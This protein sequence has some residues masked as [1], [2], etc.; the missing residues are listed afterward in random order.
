MSPLC[1]QAKQEHSI[2][3]VEGMYHHHW[4]SHWLFSIVLSCLLHH[5]EQS[6]GNKWLQQRSAVLS[7]LLWKWSNSIKNMPA[8]GCAPPAVQCHIRNDPFM[9]FSHLCNYTWGMRGDICM[10]AL[11]GE[12]EGDNKG[13]SPFSQRLSNLQLAAVSLQR[14]WTACPLSS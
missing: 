9:L 1:T 13:Q 6:K 3:R 10:P 11:W 14:A 5:I 4:W 8:A 12:E 7:L 2:T